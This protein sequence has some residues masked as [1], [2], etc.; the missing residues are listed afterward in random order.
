[1]GDFRAVARGTEMPSG[2]MKLVDLDG[3]EMGIA[4][5]DGAI[6]AFGNEC[7]H[8]AAHVS[9]PVGVSAP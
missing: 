1:M 3:E 6:F 5:V 4:N 8:R 7:T 9:W 2:E